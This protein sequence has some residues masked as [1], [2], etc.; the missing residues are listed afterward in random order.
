[1]WMR[2]GVNEISFLAPGDYEL[3]F[4]P[5]VVVDGCNIEFGG[6]ASQTTVRVTLGGATMTGYAIDS[7]ACS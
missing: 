2:A 6:D 1:M 5:L 4:Q 3:G 7:V